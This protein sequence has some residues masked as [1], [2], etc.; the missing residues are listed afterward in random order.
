MLLKVLETSIAVGRI[1]RI[2]A[3][4]SVIKLEK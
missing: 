4:R 2:L 3:R 1:I